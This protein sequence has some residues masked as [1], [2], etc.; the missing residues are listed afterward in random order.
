MTGYYDLLEKLRATLV[1]SP[2]I[3]TV[4]TGDLL[5]VDLAKQTI[6]PL[7]HLIIQNATF[8]DHV[9]TFSVSILFAD[10]VEFSKRS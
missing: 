8:S 1:A 10:I 2:S 7:A 6:F 5:E 4:T 3:N 9:I